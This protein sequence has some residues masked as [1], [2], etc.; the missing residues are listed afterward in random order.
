MSKN[1]KHIQT[2]KRNFILALILLL[3]TN[4]LMAITLSVFAKKNLR[5]QIDQ[6][7][8]DIANTAAYM[9]NG[10]ELEVLKAED[11]DTES[12]NKALDTLRAFQDNIALDYIY[13]IRQEADGSFSFTID[14][15]EEDPGEFGSPIVSTAAL[16]NAANG[17]ADVDKNAYSDEWG[18]FYS[19]YSPVYNSEGKVVGIVGVDF[20]ADWYNGKLNDNRAISIVILMAAMTIGIVLSFII[21]SDNRKRFKAILKEIRDI[22][23]SAQKLNSS[24]M[25][26]SIKK[27]DFLPDNAAGLVKEL[28]KGEEGK[29]TYF[30]EMEEATSN[31]HAVCLKLDKYVKYVDSNMYKDILTN[32]QNKAAYKNAIK[33]LDEDIKDRSPVFSVAFFDINGLEDINTHYGFEAGDELM[34]HSGII[35]KK[36]F[37][38][39][40]VYHVAGD[41]F[42]A[43][44]ENKTSLDMEEYFRSFDN[45][46]KE[47]NDSRKLAHELGIAK[48][49]CTYRTEKH[50]NYRQVFITAKERMKKDKEAY[51]QN[52]TN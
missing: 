20:S 21:R 39:D 29:E 45:E 42:I 24:I 43:L 8:L 26:T 3:L 4:A 13:G 44:M 14:P 38:K 25:Q 10:D 40:N 35:L 2:S 23:A 12:Y 6:R 7:M 31:L 47:L 46:L 34:Y 16:R 11:K 17:V 50:E 9:L 15:A 48:G 33:A 51:Y 37:G 18:S 52:K 5:E 28:A 30:D 1:E 19:A 49:R 32:T 22:D 27:L 41:E 36:V